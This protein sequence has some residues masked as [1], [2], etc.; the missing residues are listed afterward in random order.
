VTIYRSL[1]F[2]LLIYFFCN[3]AYSDDKELII[4][5][6]NNINNFSFNF[7]QT[8]NDK[9]ENGTCIIVFDNRMKCVYKNK[10]QKEIIVN[11]KTLAVIL[12]RYNKISYYPISKSIFVNILKK[13]DLLNL[14]KTST[15]GKNNGQ[16]SLK[17]LGGNDQIIRIIFDKKNFNL[18]GWKV[19]DQ[20]NN[21]ID[22]SIKIFSTNKLYNPD[23]FKIPTLN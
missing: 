21:E 3:K 15:M 14:I 2:F 18:L 6:L 13:S 5:K 19:N 16:I 22:F 23:V 7:I 17:Y 10:N 8:T 4:N 20:F 9:K 1:L 12:K 11:N